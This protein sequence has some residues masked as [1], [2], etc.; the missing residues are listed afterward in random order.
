MI[1]STGTFGGAVEISDEASRCATG[2]AT[3]LRGAT[4]GGGVEP[5]GGGGNGPGC[6]AASGHPRTNAPDNN[7]VLLAA[8]LGCRTICIVSASTCLRLS[9]SSATVRPSVRNA[10][11]SRWLLRTPHHTSSFEGF[12]VPI[13]PHFRIRTCTVG[14]RDS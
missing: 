3:S 2:G 10:S 9:Q 6:C 11:S 4:T 14:R 7:I 5:G 12:H 1:C 8:F 13:I